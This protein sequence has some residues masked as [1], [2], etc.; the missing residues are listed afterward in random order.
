MLSS[1]PRLGWSCLSFVAG[2]GRVFSVL[3]LF[4]LVFLGSLSDGL[5]FDS[6]SLCDFTACIGMSLPSAGSLQLLFG[7]LSSRRLYTPMLY[8]LFIFGGNMFFFK[9]PNLEGHKQQK[10]PLFLGVQ[11]L[12]CRSLPST[13]VFPP[14]R[15]CFSKTSSKACLWWWWC[16]LL[17]F[18]LFG[19]F[20]FQTDIN[21]ISNSIHRCQDQHLILWGQYFGGRKWIQIPCPG[22][23]GREP[24]GED[25]YLMLEK[26]IPFVS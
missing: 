14:L 26:I 12:G 2:S 8:M 13:H 1:C 21:W 9:R 7:L 17:R 19:G 3:R 4:R 16:N 10:T 18:R 5:G 11:L 23:A 24:V 6:C 25:G 22:G 15:C 20:F